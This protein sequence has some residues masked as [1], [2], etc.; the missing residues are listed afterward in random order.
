MMQLLKCKKNPLPLFPMTGGIEDWKN[1]QISRAFEIIK[2]A[3][4]MI[5]NKLIYNLFVYRGIYCIFVN[6]IKYG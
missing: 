6:K 4:T 3:E 1:Y 2:E 5:E